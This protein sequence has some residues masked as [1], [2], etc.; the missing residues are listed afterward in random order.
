M[1]QIEQ[2]FRR[3]L[4]R[5]PEVET[6][7]QNG[8]INR[9]SLARRLVKEG[10]AKGNQGEAVVAML[11]RFEFKKI[12]EKN[13]A[14]FK[15]IKINVKDRVIIFDFDKEK[16]LVRTLDKLIAHTNYD[17]GDT[18]KIVVGSSSIKVF[19]DE[20]KEGALKDILHKFHL[21]KKYKN[22]SEI[23]MIFPDVAIDEI[24]IISTVA[25]ELAVNGIVIT[26]LLTPTPELLIYVDEQYV[27][28]AYEVLKRLQR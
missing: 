21:K 20:E 5:N 19:L 11:R 14:I 3:Y 7:Y 27:L 26:E 2:D 8:L 24:G 6:C 12:Q 25:K 9:R 10:M 1:S 13:K 28:K 18:L 22:L 4:S 17:K 15:D 23:S 16:E